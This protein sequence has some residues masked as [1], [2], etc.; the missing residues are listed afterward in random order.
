MM[1]LVTKHVSLLHGSS[2]ASGNED[3]A[4]LKKDTSKICRGV[5]GRSR[6]G[7]KENAHTFFEKASRLLP[8][9]P[10]LLTAPLCSLAEYLTRVT[11]FTV[12]F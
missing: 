1:S 11:K 7:R 5:G 4:S 2:A 8:H 12:P 3:K 10:V 6:G 9:H